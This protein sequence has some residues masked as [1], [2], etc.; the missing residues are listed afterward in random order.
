MSQSPEIAQQ[1]RHLQKRC[2]QKW[3]LTCDRVSA[4]SLHSC[5]SAARQR[6]HPLCRSKSGRCWT[7]ECGLS[8]EDGRVDSD[9]R[10][11]A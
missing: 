6:R 3:R 10:Q 8:D 7:V 4:V 11:S 5:A 1:N 2:R 9:G